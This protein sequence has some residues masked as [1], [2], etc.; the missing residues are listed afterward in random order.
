M[1]KYTF[2]LDEEIARWAFEL[3][4]RSI[5]KWT[6]AFTNPTAGPWKRIEATDK[7]GKRGEVYRFSRDEK[8]PDIVLYNDELEAILIVEAKDNLA[9]LTAAKQAE[10]SAAVTNNIANTLSALGNNPFWAARSKYT[11]HNGLLWAGSIRTSEAQIEALFAM[12]QA[13]LLRQKSPL[14]SR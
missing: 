12:Y 14:A 7:H 2:R 1:N 6:I 13:A 5:A 8:R 9:K 11:T 10:K 4:V 3:R